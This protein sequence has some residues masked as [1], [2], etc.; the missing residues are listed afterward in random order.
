MKLFPF[1]RTSPSQVSNFELCARKWWLQSVVKLPTPE[2][3]AKHFG[4][5][6]HSVVERYFR[7]DDTGR[8]PDG[9]P[10]DLFPPGWD[11]AYAQKWR[12]G[13]PINTDKPVYK[14]SPKE[15]A[16]M[17]E[18]IEQGVE[19]GVLER[20]PGREIEKRFSFEVVDGIIAQGSIDV[21]VPPYEIQDNKTTK[22]WRYAKGE[23]ALAQDR[24]VL[25]Y[26]YVAL[27]WAKEAKG[28]I[29]AKFLV[30]HNVF[31]KDPNEERRVKKTEVWVSREDV[32]AAWAEVRQLTRDMLR[33]SKIQS[34]ADI[35]DPDP[36]A[37]RAFGGC[38][39]LRLCG[40]QETIDRYTQRVR[41]LNASRH[42]LA[43]S[44]SEK[45][46]TMSVFDN[47][48]KAKRGTSPA[49]EAPAIPVV[50]P[51]RQEPVKAPAPTTV[52]EDPPPM[53]LDAAKEV[54]AACGKPPWADPECKACGQ[55]WHN[56]FNSRGAPCRICLTTAPAAGRP[57]EL[58]RFVVV[59]F[60]WEEA[61]AA[62]APAP[63][64]APAAKEEEPKPAPEAPDDTLDEEVAPTI[65]EAAAQ[66][67]KVGRRKATDS[68]PHGAGRKPKTFTLLLGCAPIRVS[69]KVLLIED[70]FKQFRDEL[71]EAKGVDNFWDLDAWRRKDAM[72]Y[73]AEQIA[74]RL[75]TAT[76]VCTA[77]SGSQDLKAFID[78]L[79][80]YASTIIQSTLS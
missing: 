58:S 20:R 26:A 40:R 42:S 31:C 59:P 56:G 77:S 79:R 64:S 76:V 60:G 48:M 54:Y 33:V 10:V 36:G 5:I 74:D 67:P 15:A 51:P 2:T 52:S 80:P 49:P 75:G 27:Q 3:D 28:I 1:Q 32:E 12:D 4:T 45:E 29:P 69:G 38:P 22:Q 71:C 55:A 46:E 24:Q 50:N 34:P 9:K 17:R 18:M 66:P 19:H 13:V 44:N 53:R 7:A 63:T 14:L 11:I 8:G 6:F 62:P 61:A 35:P 25:W 21:F 78:A 43:L 73:V 68:N 65:A 41:A 30:R 47:L 23:K 37:C 70:I 16:L 39:F 72:S 57:V